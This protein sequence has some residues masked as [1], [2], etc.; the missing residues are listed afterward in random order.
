MAGF[1]VRAQ[2]PADSVPQDYNGLRETV[3]LQTSKGVYETGEDL[4]FK[5]Y[6]FDAQ[7]LAL[8]GRSRT[9]FVEMADGKDSIV[10]QEKYPI[11]A[12]MAEGHIYVDK[13]LRPGNYRIHAYTR[14][15]FLRDTLMPI[16]PKVIR[17][18]K[19]IADK[20][21]H[22]EAA[23]MPDTV[24]RL[25]F[26]PEGGDLVNGI[27]SKVAFKA[28]DYREMPVPV[29]GV[30]EENGRV[31]ARLESMQDSMGSFMLLPRR[32]AT[33]K[34]VLSNGREFSFC[35]IEASGLALRLNKQTEQFLDFQL[36]QPNGDKP[37][38]V[39]LVGRMRG[40]TCCTAT[41]TLHGSVR[42]RMPVAPL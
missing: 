5:G 38:T 16:Y 9:L 15:S 27:P 40:M 29:E 35:P 2:A 24:A 8:S 21:E 36:S 41:A 4:W 12:G 18:V 23:S 32:D 10:W 30:L 22:K 31:V 17:V 39:R 7:T 28:T 1:T 6:A 26:F 11:H 42:V 33:Y 37:Q 20:L 25:Q 19:E 13:N 3:Y 14:H 34:A